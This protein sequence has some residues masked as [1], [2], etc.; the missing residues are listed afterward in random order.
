MAGLLPRWRP[1]P[2]TP[3]AAAGP[4]IDGDTALEVDDLLR[5]IS[6]HGM[7]ALSP[8]EHEFLRKA[9]QRYRDAGA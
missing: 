6:R 3:V 9:S 8:E 5:K 7:T 1:R 2:V 4:R